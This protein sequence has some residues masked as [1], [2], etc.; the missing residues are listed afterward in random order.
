MEH[1]ITVLRYYLVA[2]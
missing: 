1:G 2:R